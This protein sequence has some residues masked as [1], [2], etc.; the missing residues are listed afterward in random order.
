MLVAPALLPLGVPL[1]V[2]HFFVLF[3]AVSSG[4]TPPVAL[5]ALVASGLASANYMKTAFESV[6]VGLGFYIIPFLFIGSPCLLLLGNIDP[7]AMTM[8]IIASASGLLTIM[9]TMVG[10][11]LI[12]TNP[13]QRLMAVL[14]AAG[15]LGY[16]MVG[17]YYLFGM[18][19][20]ILILLTIWQWRKRLALKQ[21]EGLTL[22]V[23]ASI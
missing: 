22:R 23:Q 12:M 3:A 2:T 19:Q 16:C 7:L 9:I 15:S 21:A 14:S 20:V 6:K 1:E 4:L 17:N 10:C 11:Y 5:A 8:T 18:G 13:L